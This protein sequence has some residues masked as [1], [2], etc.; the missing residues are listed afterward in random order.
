MGGRLLRAWLL[1]P[2]A[3]LEP[4]RDRLDAVEELAFRTPERGKLRETL[5]SVQDLERLVVARGA[6]RRPARATSWAS[7]SRSPP[8]RACGWCSTDC[9]APLVR[10]LVG[11]LDDLA[12]VRDVDRRG[13]PGRAAGARPRRRLRPRRRR[14]GHRRAAAHQPLR[15]AGDRRDG[16]GASA[17]APAS[18][19]SRS[20]STACSAT[21]SRCRSRTSTRCRPTTSASRRSPAASAS[22]RRR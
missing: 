9:Q 19:R 17:R 3:A 6:R 16:R 10:S 14:P 8:S 1:R 4:I 7:A 12:D 11:E 2:L 5:K 22:S 20:A 15:Q 21:T 13:H 18:R